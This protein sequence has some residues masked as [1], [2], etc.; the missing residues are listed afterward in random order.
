MGWD[1]RSKAVHFSMLSPLL[2]LIAHKLGV[3][4]SCVEARW[5]V[6]VDDPCHLERPQHRE[7][8]ADQVDALLQEAKWS[9]PGAR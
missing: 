3:P 9:G 5:S 6:S 8:L 4:Q 1:T 7:N 2:Q